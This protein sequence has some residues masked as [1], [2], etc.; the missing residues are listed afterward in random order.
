M[1]VGSRVNGVR[2]RSMVA[3]ALA[4]AALAVPLSAQ[5]VRGVVTRSQ[6]PIAGVVVQLLD[7]ANAV[8]ARTLTDELGEYR[9]LAPR[10]GT[11][12]LDARRIGFSPL[13]SAS[14][15]LRDGETRVQPL[16][17]DGIAVS[18]DTVRVRTNRTDC[19][20]ADA[21]NAEVAL[22]WEQART[23]LMA[24]DATLSGRAMSAA[25]LKYRRT[26]YPDGQRT[27]QSMS[28]TDVDSA[29]APWTSESF[30]ELQRVGY[31]VVDKDSTSFR[32]PG[33]DVLASDEFSSSMCF[34]VVATTDAALIALSF[35]PAKSR[36]NI[37]ELRGTLTLDRQTAA[38]RSL[39]F[40]YTNLRKVLDDAGAGGRM[41]FVTMRDGGWAIGRW[42]IRMP[43]IARTSL[44]VRRG[45][46][47][48]ETIGAI[49]VGGGDLL[50]ARHGTDTLWKRNVPPVAGLVAD[51]ATGVSIRG[52]RLRLR[53]TDRE[54][55]TDST[56]HFTFTQLMPG[57]YTMLVNTPSLDSL[58]AVS[59]VQMLVADT[60][61]AITVRVPNAARV[62]PQVCRIPADSLALRTRLGV[63]RGT[64][65]AEHD[66]LAPS[67]TNVLVQWRDS[68]NAAP[69]ILRI[70]TDDAGNYRFCE[71]PLN[72]AI[73]V[74]A[75]YEAMSSTVTSVIVAPSAPYVRLDLA[76]ERPLVNEAVVGGT[77]VDSSGTPLEGVSVDVPVLNLHTLTD[78][79][80]VFRVAHVT[81]GANLVTWRKLGYSAKDQS[82]V[83][84]P[85]AV[86]N[87]K[88]VLTRV[89]TVAAVTT[90]AN[91]IWMKEFEENKKLGLGQFLTRE[92]LAKKEAVGLGALLSSMRGTHITFAKGN[93]ATLTSSR[94]GP[95]LS[96]KSCYSQIFLDNQPIYT[97]RTGEPVPNL[98]EYLVSS[99]EAIEWFAGPAETPGKY[100]NL[101]A[102]CGVLVLHTRQSGQ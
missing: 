15:V 93:K 19:A 3:G 22:V 50:V 43:L 26:V 91:M 62:M 6:V 1:L 58:G 78:G 57:E 40:R 66:S 61:A 33:L 42:I 49:E 41:E 76:L 10:A 90:T 96:A 94:P 2:I 84:P 75:E 73:E 44:Q 88:I 20:K 23:A 46:S 86:T 8:V 60:V 98:N 99:L 70:R 68:T 18:L 102:T 12:R 87:L 7:S 53:N 28:L 54:T 27:L 82:L 83:L 63:L 24:T 95:S 25:L 17:V 81:A 55:L 47:V 59:A 14:F 45:L 52:A 13:T 56:G 9:F 74:R 31:V 35:E 89:Q 4:F 30:Q 16:S 72:T 69:T 29:L 71:M 48:I 11:Y 64:V 37:S 101:N 77:V 39:E 92:E 100:N 34:K 21:K 85:S 51:S 38:L 65:K 97:G 32:A 5:S 67:L 80:G 79:R 36:K